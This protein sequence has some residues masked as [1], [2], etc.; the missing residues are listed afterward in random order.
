M[1]PS[2]FK[3]LK[4]AA[5]EMVAIEKGRKKIS[6][7]RVHTYAIPHAKAIREKLKMTQEEFCKCFGIELGTLRQWE[8]GR[9]NPVGPAAVLLRVIASNPKAVTKALA[10]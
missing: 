2:D 9:R 5:R 8:Q 4:A 1:N 6:P 10:G 3:K 7:R